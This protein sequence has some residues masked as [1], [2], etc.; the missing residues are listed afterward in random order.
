MILMM[1]MIAYQF[2]IL[3]VLDDR[4]M[5]FMGQHNT[6]QRI[7]AKMAVDVIKLKDTVR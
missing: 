6:L 1:G 7:T 4:D 5:E 3:N 2:Y